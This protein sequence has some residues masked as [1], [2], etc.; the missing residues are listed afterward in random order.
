MALPS[1]DSDA[2][3]AD[4]IR[5]AAVEEFDALIT[6]KRPDGPSV[7][8]PISGTRTPGTPGEVLIQA[9]RGRAQNLRAP[10]EFDDGNGWQTKLAYRV[11]IDPAPGDPSITKGLLV[12]VA[13]G[14][15]PELVKMTLHVGFAANSTHMAVRTIYCATE[16][17]RR[18]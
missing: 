9:R 18:A 8:D 4:E 3:W 16:G 10:V 12:L 13:D 14:R 6:V 15:D 2:H 17:Y 11:Q 5:D 1:R 7:L